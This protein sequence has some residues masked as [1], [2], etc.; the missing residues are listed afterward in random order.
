MNFFRSALCISICLLRLLASKNDLPQTEHWGRWLLE[1][2][3]LDSDL[4]FSKP[5]STPNSEVTKKEQS[6]KS[7]IKKCNIKLA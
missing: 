1:P 6:S 2:E 7:K 3:E 5:L 4:Y